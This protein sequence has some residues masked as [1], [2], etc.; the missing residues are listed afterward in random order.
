MADRA[1]FLA[2]LAGHVESR[3]NSG[4]VRVGIDGVDGAGKT[5]LAD[6]LAVLLQSRGHRVIRASV[7]G[8]HNPRAVRYRLG[9][10]SSE[11]FYRDTTNV[12]LLREVLL[13]PLSP[14]GSGRYRTRAFDHRTDQP[15]AEPAK[16]A[17]PPAILLFDGIFLHRPELRGDWDLS[18]FLDVPFAESY[19]RMAAR[20]GSDPDPDAAS[21]R[22]YFDGQKL[23]LI[24]CDP[25]SAADVHIDYAGL[26]APRI[27]RG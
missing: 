18:I 26:D 21:N 15:V 1:A 8:F 22:R 24:E 4:I 16:S 11:G 9:R 2:A 13:D 10:D 17:E 7:D 5:M 20:D 23:Y 19:R 12:A 3:M 14:G 25:R 27:V 6:E